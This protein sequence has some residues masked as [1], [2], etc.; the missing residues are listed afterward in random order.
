M[1]RSPFSAG[2]PEASMYSAH[3]DWHHIMNAVAPHTLP[4]SAIAAMVAM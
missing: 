3:T 1:R 4:A 2:L